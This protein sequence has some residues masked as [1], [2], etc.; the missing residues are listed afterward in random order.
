MDLSNFRRIP[1]YNCYIHDQLGTENS[2]IVRS[3]RAECQRFLM[4]SFLPTSRAMKSVLG[5]RIATDVILT[6]M[7][8]GPVGALSRLRNETY[9]M[10]GTA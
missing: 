8:P 2:G 9:T 7:N 3:Y 4:R 1:R 10:A 5:K 6:P